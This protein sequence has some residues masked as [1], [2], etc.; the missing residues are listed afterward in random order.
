EPLKVLSG[1]AQ[2]MRERRRENA[3]SLQ[4]GDKGSAESPRV[5]FLDHLV[6]RAEQMQADGRSVKSYMSER[7]SRGPLP[8][9]FRK[10][11]AKLAGDE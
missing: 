8:V 3:R 11:R 2:S 1:M 9:T 10:A 5:R 4:H 6:L 7:N